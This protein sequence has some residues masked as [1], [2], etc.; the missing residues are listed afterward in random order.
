MKVS[1]VWQNKKK[2]DGEEEE[3]DAA[4]LGELLSGLKK[5]QTLPAAGI[6]IKEGETSPPSRYNTGSLILAMENAGQLIEDEDLRAQ[7]KGSGIGTS[8]TRAEILK[9]LETHR[10]LSVV[11]K[12]QIVQPT[13]LG[14]MIFDTVA[15]SIKPLLNA[16]LTASWELGLSRTAEG[17]ITADE[18]MAKLDDFIR[19]RVAAVKNSDFRPWLRSAFA[20]TASFY[21]SWKETGTQKKTKGSKKS[22][23]DKKTSGKKAEET[24]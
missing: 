13:Q 24:S 20:H 21:Q 15:C 12:T 23:A 7:I 9:K 18:Y 17:T 8:A 6:D 14:E 2:T 10:Y 4:G 11:K 3:Q 22:L 19:R 5:G 1:G 16:E